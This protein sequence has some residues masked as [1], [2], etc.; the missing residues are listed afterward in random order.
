[1]RFDLLLLLFLGTSTKGSFSCSSAMLIRTRWTVCEVTADRPRGS[2]GLS[3]RS[4]RTVREVPDSPAVLR[5]LA[6]FLSASLSI[7]FVGGFLVHEVCGRSVLECQTVRDEVDG[8]RIHH[9]RSV[10]LG[11][12]LEVRVAFSDGS[13]PPRGQSAR[14][15]RTVRL[16]LSRLS[17]SFAFSVVLLCWIELGF[18]PRVGRSVST[19]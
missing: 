10:F 19:T 7:L 9:G 4:P 12:V 3:A 6:G 2:H 15:L 1:M 5:V 11:A 17:K 14:T 13:C 18:V 16:V 8:P